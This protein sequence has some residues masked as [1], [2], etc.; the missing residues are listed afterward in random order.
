MVDVPRQNKTY[1]NKEYWNERFVE[2]KNYEWLETFETLQE[3][4]AA[5]IRPEDSILVIGCG[6]SSL[7]SDLYD[8]GYHDITSLDYSS[9]VIGNLK[10]IHSEA[11]PEMKWVCA[12]MRE[13]HQTFS[14]SSFDVVIDKAGMDALLT[15]EKSVWEPN[16]STI[17]DCHRVFTGVSSVLKNNGYFLQVTFSQP[18]FHRR[19]IEG[20]SEDF[21]P[22]LGEVGKVTSDK[23]EWTGS[24]KTLTHEKKFDNFLWILQKQV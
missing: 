3:H 2:E 1:K 19:Y 18:H 5:F 6:S 14:Q 4:I 22:V 24:V 13:L 9:V 7:S 21:E 8:A 11:R 16:E 10:E 15:D 12:D 20:P 17:Q 23:Y